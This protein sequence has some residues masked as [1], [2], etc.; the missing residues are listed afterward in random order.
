V[1]GHFGDLVG[2]KYTFLVT[3]L[4]MGVSRFLVG[5]LPSHDT[6]G[7]AAPVLL[8]TLRLTQGLALGGEYGGAVDYVAERAPN[9]RRGF[10]L[11]GWLSDRI[12]CKPIILAGCFVAAISYFYSPCSISSRRRRGHQLDDAIELRDGIV[13]ASPLMHSHAE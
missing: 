2:R 4:I 11:F 9:R 12:G 6:M 1:L 8:I 13:G 5:T 3:I 7:W 10:V